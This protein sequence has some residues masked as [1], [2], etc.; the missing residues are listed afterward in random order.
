LRTGYGAGERNFVRLQIRTR[1]H[2]PTP[3]ETYEKFQ[4]LPAQLNLYLIFNRGL[5]SRKTIIL[6]TPEKYATH[7]TGQAQKL[8]KKGRFSKV[9]PN[10]YVDI[11]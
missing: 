10:R 7:S 9:S 8:S 5:S 6:T 3:L 11:L 2:R 1:P 4:F